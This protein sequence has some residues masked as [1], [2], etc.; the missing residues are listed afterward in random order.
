MSC[1]FQDV[2]IDVGFN[3]LVEVFK[4]ILSVLVSTA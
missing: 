1:G 2:V 3:H 4:V